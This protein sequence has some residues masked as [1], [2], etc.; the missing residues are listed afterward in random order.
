MSLW[1]KYSAS[2]APFCN[3][4]QDC[5]VSDNAIIANKSFSV[6]I[7]FSFKFSVK[8]RMGDGGMLSFGDNFFESNY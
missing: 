3:V 2:A 5:S 8:I 7:V 6:F 1:P 4:V